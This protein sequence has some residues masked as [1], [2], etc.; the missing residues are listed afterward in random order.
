MNLFVPVAKDNV[1]VGFREKRGSVSAFERS[2][3]EANRQ[4]MN[5]KGREQTRQRGESY[6]LELVDIDAYSVNVTRE[7]YFSF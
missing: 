7:I 4:T 6:Y 2:I 5:P 3:T 1:D